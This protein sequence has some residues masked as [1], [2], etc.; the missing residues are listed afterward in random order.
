MIVFETQLKKL[1]YEVLK[2]VI[3]LT[4]QDKLN[5]EELEKIPYEIIKGNKPVYRCCVHKE[6]AI[7]LERAKLAMGCFPTGNIIDELR[8]IKDDDQIMYVIESACDR[9]PI[10]RFTVTEAC[11]GCIQHKCMEVCPAHAITKIDGRAYINQELCKECGMCKQ[12]CPYNAISDVKRPCKSSCPTG[13]LEVRLSDRIATIEQE[14]CINC[15]ACMAACPFGAISDKSYIVPV[16]RAVLDKNKKVFAVVAPAIAGQFGQDVNMGQIKE[17][18][19][20]I[21]FSDMIEAACGADAVTIHETN[22]FV[23]RMKNNENYM[24][25]SCCSGVVNYIEKKFKSEVSKISATVSPMIAAAR[26]IKNENKEAIVVFVGPCTAKKSEML[27]KE[28]KGP[29]DYVLTFEELMSLMGALEINPVNLEGVEIEDASLYGRN[30]AKAGGLTEAIKN[31]IEDKKITADFRP[32]KASGSVEIKKALS[33]AKV[34]KLPGN[35]IEGM[36]CEDG[37]IG[38]AGNMIS[39]QKSKIQLNKF[40]KTS[41]NINV[42][43]NPNLDRFKEVKLEK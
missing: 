14:D 26:M 10:N 13:A 32:F 24:V 42:S 37:C 11:R 12:V 35:F 5:K 7:V 25:N 28:V 16:T 3:L 9:C 39:R 22:E 4:I 21:G 1:K 8:D 33:L 38:G 31:Y 40:S 17:A 23:E 27:R 43:S 15:G 29:V 41:K 34:G 18:F 6:R 36:M 19:L 2:K 30:F 20:K